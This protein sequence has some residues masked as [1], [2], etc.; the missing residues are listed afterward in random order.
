MALIA[1]LALS[2]GLAACGSSSSPGSSSS[3]P[4]AAASPAASGSSGTSDSSSGLY[5]Y[6][7]NMPPTSGPKAARN[8]TIWIISCGQAASGCAN[9]TAD[10][11]QAAGAIGWKAL[12]CDGKFDVNDAYG[13]CITQGLADH[14]SGIALSSGFDCDLVQ[15]QLKAAKAAGIP[16]VANMSVDCND[17]LS[18]VKG[19]ALF[20]S[21][22]M[23]SQEPSIQQWMYARGEAV[24]KY[25][26]AKTG[27]H[28]QIIDEHFVGQLLGV[29][30]NNGFLAGLKS[31]AGCN[32]VASVSINNAVLA[33]GQD[34]QL[35]S[36]AAVQHP[37]ANVI[38]Y[39]FSSFV[40]SSQLQAIAS[41]MGNHPLVVGGEGEPNNLSL[42]SS[43][44]S[45]PA[46][47][48]AYNG[49]QLGWALVDE[50]NRVFAG[51]PPVSEGIGWVMADRGHNLPAASQYF[52]PPDNFMV[53]YKKS[54][55]VS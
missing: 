38:A 18:T 53:I 32:V 12:I 15:P 2:A 26:I 28:G 34:H 1:L 20:T 46:A 36:T 51:Q 29:Y 40:Q 47:E 13:S 3:T 11:Q 31:C 44:S 4:G 25:I 14:V 22:L 19:P 37:S 17:P 24:A 54:W 16:V 7:G 9:T 6:T 55:G 52:S 50:L 39:A 45:A 41:Q 27:G 48:A 49:P 8:K 30:Q 5:G 21:L 33:Q 10:I 43:G 23:S 35:M 42:I